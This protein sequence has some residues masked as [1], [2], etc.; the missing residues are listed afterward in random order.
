[1]LKRLRLRFVLVIMVLVTGMLCLIF[2]LV[3]HFTQENLEA[4]SLNMMR[5]VASAPPHPDRPGEPTPQVKL[6]YFT[7]QLGPHGELVATG[8][9][10]YDLSD[11]AFLRTLVAAVLEQDAQTG[12]L[13]R[14]SLRFCRVP[15]PMGESLVFAD[16][17]SE[18]STLHHLARSCVLIGV[19]CLLGFLG[20]SLLLARWTVKPVETAWRQQRQF[21]ADASHELK[22]PLTVI[23]T[24]AELLQSP[25]YDAASRA[26][27]SRSIL[28]MTQQMRSL[29]ER[30]LTLAQADSGQN[31]APFQPFDFSALVADALL[32]F[33]PVFFEKGLTFSSQVQE[34]ITVNGSAQQL[35]QV[36]DILLDNAQKYASG[37]GEV[38]VS[39]QQTGKH[40]CLLSVSNPGETIPAAELKNIFKRFYRL[41]KAR[42]RDGGFGLGLSIA[43]QLVQAH[44]GRIWA[45][46]RAGVVRFFVELPGRVS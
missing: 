20:I 32:P 6:P 39:L 43:E 3:Y 22:T 31:K 42:Q 16:I 24:N 12:L 41:D 46:S 29:V 38:C 1:M 7:I 8:G 5:N 44:H 9:G 10:Y 27:F 11:E 19:L 36:I 23:M 18:R 40:S 37:E 25:S 21:V 30:L 14:Y 28:T 34:G 33:E 17:T 45:E 26:Q 15:N 13:E 4:E 35:Q 2:G